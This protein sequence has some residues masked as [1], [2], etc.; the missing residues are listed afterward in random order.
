MQNFSIRYLFID[1]YFVTEYDDETENKKT[2]LHMVQ[3]LW[4]F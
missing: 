3:F 2:C 1:G 4:V